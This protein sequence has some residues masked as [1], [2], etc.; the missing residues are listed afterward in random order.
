MINIE[1]RKVAVREPTLEVLDNQSINLVENTILF[2][3][4]F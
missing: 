2:L 4:T 3:D 1:K